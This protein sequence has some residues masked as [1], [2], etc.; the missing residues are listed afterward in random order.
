[1]GWVIMVWAII[2]EVGRNVLA[3]L[4]AKLGV[5][6]A[7]KRL[8]ERHKKPPNPILSM[9]RVC[10]THKRRDNS[11]QRVRSQFEKVT[12]LGNI[13]KS[14]ESFGRLLATWNEKLS[15]RPAIR[16]S[17]DI[18]GDLWTT[19]SDIY[20][21]EEVDDLK[22]GIFVTN[23]RI[24]SKLLL[25]SLVHLQVKHQ[26]RQIGKPIMYV[27][28]KQIPSQWPLNGKGMI[29][30]PLIKEV[31]LNYE[32]SF[33]QLLEGTGFSFK[34][35]II[36]SN[37]QQPRKTYTPQDLYCDLKNNDLYQAYI[38]TLH[39]KDQAVSEANAI[40]VKGIW[41][42][43]L[44]D[45]VL[46]GIESP[47]C[48]FWQWMVSTT[49]E[50]GHPVMLVAIYDH[51]QLLYNAPFDGKFNNVNDFVRALSNAVSLA[52]VKTGGIEAL[53]ILDITTQ[54]GKIHDV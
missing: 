26:E 19:I 40:E 23:I 9:W 43:N 21:Q 11:L 38:T 14:R 6:W 42:M 53:Q 52:N 30:D 25:G 36:V 16:G 3:E 27:V 31:L 51:N 39:H 18:S 46:F 13:P 7:K 8:A 17:G 37:D 32:Q 1:M 22:K 2:V 24:Y 34:R 4:G 20:L 54:N 15:L 47:G 33:Q 48:P 10:R 44:S 49:M 12:Y 45:L 41:P 28:T 35:F 5:N 29:T 50:I